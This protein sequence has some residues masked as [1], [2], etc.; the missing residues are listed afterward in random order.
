MTPLSK[1]LRSWVT[2]GTSN[3]T[4]DS[5][6]LLGSQ[7]WAR[8]VGQMFIMQCGHVI[9]YFGIPEETPNP[10]WAWEQWSNRDS[11]RKR[12][13]LR[14]AG[15]W[16][17]F[18]QHTRSFQW[19]LHLQ[20]ESNTLNP[21]GSGQQRMTNITLCMPLSGTGFCTP[22]T[23]LRWRLIVITEL[24]HMEMRPLV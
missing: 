13:H 4:P 15:F 16:G 3:R 24:F 7:R 2:T 19:S 8:K 1:P 23:Q 12:G 9:G 20:M 21:G 17:S 18:L 11:G 5:M 6:G 14:K 10:D 22:Q